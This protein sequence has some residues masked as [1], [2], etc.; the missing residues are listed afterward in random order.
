VTAPA[1]TLAKLPPAELINLTPDVWTQ[2]F[3]AAAVEHRLVIPRCTSCGTFRLPPSAFCW[4]CQAQE[5]E[6]I[7]HAGNG[8]VYSYTV[9]HHPLL[10]ELA[11]SVPYVPAVVELPDTNGCRLVGALTEVRLRDVRV[12]MDVEL[13]WRDVREGETVPTFRPAGS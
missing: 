10:P 9:I 7:E 11:D 1:D 12:G 5:V 13:V 2:P 6:W 3:W 4:S 8:A